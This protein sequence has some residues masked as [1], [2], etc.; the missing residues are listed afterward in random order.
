MQGAVFGPLLLLGLHLWPHAS[1]TL[2]FTRS[3]YAQGAVWQLASAQ[4]V[5][6]N[7]IH[8]WGNALALGVTL[9][10]WRAWVGWRTQALAL[11]GGMLG[12]AVVLAL[13]PQCTYYAGLSGA[14]Y[15]L[16]AGNAVAL[17][18]NAPPSPGLTPA[19][20]HTGR[21]RWLIAFGLLALLLGR[22]WWQSQAG[23]EA[24]ASWLAIP[25]YW[26]AHAAG[27]AGGLVLAGGALLRRAAARRAP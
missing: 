8:T 3:A 7:W 2:R 1:E 5:H 6:L 16:W 24:A 26:P 4:V 20:G 18:G 14:L 19:N 25:V 27:L 17:L 11:G 22:L 9:L 23:P 10:G 21:W 15:G 13:D 12:V